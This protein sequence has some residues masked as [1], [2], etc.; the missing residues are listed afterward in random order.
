MD[1]PLMELFPSFLFAC[2]C[3]EFVVRMRETGIPSS[4]DS[5][6]DAITGKSSEE[7]SQARS[8]HPEYQSV[9]YDSLG[10]CSYYVVV[11]KRK[12]FNGRRLCQGDCAKL[13][14]DAQAILPRIV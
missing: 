5:V 4:H 3:A 14:H 7:D 11:T 10:L 12:E 2:I 13:C 9:N 8:Y 6:K 1:N